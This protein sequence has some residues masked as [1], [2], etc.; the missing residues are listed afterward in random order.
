MITK[1]IQF[2]LGIGTADLD[3]KIKQMN[4]FLSAGHNVKLTCKL[5]GRYKYKPE[6]AV[7]FLNEHTLFATIKRKTNG[8]PKVSNKGA[9]VTVL[10]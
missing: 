9:T 3:R 8:P 5:R 2:T 1:E 4:E 6:L 7:A 10:C